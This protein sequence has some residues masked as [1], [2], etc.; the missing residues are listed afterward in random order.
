MNGQAGEEKQ[1]EKGEKVM[2]I[3]R[4]QFLKGMATLVV[5]SQMPWILESDVFAAVQTQTLNFRITDAMKEMITHNSINDARC[6]FWIYKSDAPDL[7]ADCPGPNIFCTQ[8]DT[9]S[10]T[11]TNDLDEPHA[12]FIPGV[13]SSGPIAPAETKTFSFT[14]SRAGSFLYYDNLN[15]PV[16]RVMGLHGAF[17]VMPRLA[18]PGH[19][20]TPYD[21]PTPAVQ[22]LFDDLGTAG[23]FP[24]LSW[25]AGD[26]ANH[27][28]P[29]RQYVWVLHQA[30]PVL[31]AEVG[32]LPPGQIYPAAQFVNAMLN[33]PY[34]N[35]F[36]TGV[37]NRKAQYYT[38]NGQSGFFGHHNGYICPKL[39]VG[40]PCIVRVL[41]AGLYL[42]SMH[43][44]ANHIY[45]ISLNRR[46]QDN[47]LWVDTIQAVPLGGFDWLV[48]FHRPP[49][50][51]NTRGIGLPDPP[52]T[53]VN[54]GKTWPPEEELGTYFPPVG[55]LADPLNPNSV[56]ISVQQSP[57]C[58]PMHD[59]CEPSQVAQ[60]GNYN[61]GLMSGMDF[62]G[63]RTMEGGIVTFPNASTEHG[64]DATG[65]AAGPDHAGH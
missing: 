24:G 30:S 53:T 40:E 44:H 23:H 1:T 65:P 34:A 9:I 26:M 61:F 20:F 63:D 33:D 8:G 31:F 4:R 37:M 55:T 62:I 57:L 45:V 60:G 54:G 5:G 42:H 19:K 3:S 27:T 48:P 49:D 52:L 28:P 17:I 50:I 59:H 2:E 10:I 22:R 64:P 32:S 58:Y 56:D 38:L 51:P 13:F 39:R 15:A 36:E 21:R 29:F 46:V 25:E 43:M 41:N 7:P 6:Y 14:A 12:F 18:A 47:V 16:N 11:L 35:A